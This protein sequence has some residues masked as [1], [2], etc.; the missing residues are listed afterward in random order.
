MYMYTL[1]VC[2]ECA[3]I[4]TCASHMESTHNNGVSCSGVV[5]VRETVCR[6]TEV[7]VQS[8]ACRKGGNVSEQYNTWS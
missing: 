4:R 6:D 3:T 7:V 8:Q 1:R 5:V 2:I